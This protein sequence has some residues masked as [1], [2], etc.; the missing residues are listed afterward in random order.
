L[1]GGVVKVVPRLIGGVVEVVM[2]LIG[3]VVSER[4]EVTTV[5]QFNSSEGY[6]VVIYRTE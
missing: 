5:D 2:R 4:S 3:G 1:I 6:L